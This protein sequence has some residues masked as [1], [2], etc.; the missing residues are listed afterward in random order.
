MP[1]TMW[2][3]AAKKAAEERYGHLH[4]RRL[5]FVR[6][7]PKLLLLATVVGVVWLAVKGGQAGARA[8]DGGVPAR[9]WVMLAGAVVVAAVLLMVVRRVRRPYRIPRRRFWSRY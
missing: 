6:S 9:G 8:V 3:D 1:H 5:A 4:W 2:S 7:L